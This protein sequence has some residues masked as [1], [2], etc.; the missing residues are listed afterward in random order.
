MIVSR[1]EMSLK[2]MIA[3]RVTDEYSIHRIVYSLFPIQ[4][5]QVRDFIFC[6]KGGTA[7]SRNILIVSKREPLKPQ[8]GRVVSKTIPDSFLSHDRYGFEIKINPTYEI[9]RELFIV[10]GGENIL[11]WF[12]KDSPLWGFKVDPDHLDFLNLRILKFKDKNLRNVT[13]GAATISGRLTVSDR[14]LF[15]RSFEYGI[16]PGKCWGLGLLQLI[17]QN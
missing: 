16:N 3:M 17:V 6:D 4:K 14:D 15:K 11:E 12:K 7:T 5:D 8:Y 10:K 1:Y 9:N 2:D 13:M